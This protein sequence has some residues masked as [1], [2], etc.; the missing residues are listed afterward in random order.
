[1]TRLIRRLLNLFRRPQARPPVLTITGPTLEA[2]LRARAMRVCNR[3]AD[4]VE[5]YLRRHMAL[6]TRRAT[7]NE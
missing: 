2:R 1:M 6:S 5:R 4:D 3:D 7:G